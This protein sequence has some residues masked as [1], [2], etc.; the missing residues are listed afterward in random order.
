MTW[1]G[2]DDCVPKAWRNKESTITMR[3]KPVI[4]NRI[5]G[6]KDSAV[7][8]SKVWTG[9]EKLILE[10]PVPTNRGSCPEFCAET[11][12]CNATADRHKKTLP[13][14]ARR[15]KQY[16]QK[17]MRVGTLHT[18]DRCPSRRHVYV[19]TLR[20]INIDAMQ[21]RNILARDPKCEPH[22]LPLR[23]HLYG[24][25]ALVRPHSQRRNKARLTADIGIP[26]RIPLFRPLQSRGQTHQYRQKSANQNPGLRHCTRQLLLT[27]RRRSDG[28]TT[29]VKRIPNLS[30][31]TTTSP[32][33]IR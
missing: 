21:T 1:F 7:K 5:A 17:L 27:R 2:G 15:F 33:A 28:V 18:S 14:K 19:A 6:K 29:S 13:K 31:T 9:T 12:A 23:P 26:S 20:V 16:L 3:V 11:V 24:N 22:P 25:H 4:I 30:L 32:C 8:K 10:P